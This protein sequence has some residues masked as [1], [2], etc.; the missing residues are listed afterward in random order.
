MISLSSFLSQKNKN[1]S[2][3]EVLSAQD[4]DSLFYLPLSLPAWE[5]MLHLQKFLITMPYREDSPD[6]WTFIWGN[7]MYTSRQYYNYVYEN[8]Q[9][10][11]IYKVLR[12]SKCTQR[13]KFFYLVV[14]S[15]QTEYKGYAT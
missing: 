11:R 13:I 12:S 14:A 6:E 5:E 4:L 2:V 1:A 10:L 3:H 8:L 9:V 7:Q 15:G